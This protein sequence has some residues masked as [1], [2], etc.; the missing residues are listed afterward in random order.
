L[1]TWEV[2]SVFY[3][4]DASILLTSRSTEELRTKINSTLDYMIDWF[5]V[6][7]FLG[8][9]KTS[10]TIFTP[11]HCQNEPFPSTYHNKVIAGSNNIK[12]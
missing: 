11:S 12:F 9:E 8:I 4:D 7:G 5:S 1:L 6:K 10:T 2:K 3:A